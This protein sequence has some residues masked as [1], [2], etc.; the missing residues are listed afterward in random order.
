[1]H[2]MLLAL[3]LLALIALNALYVAAEFAVLGATRP[4]VESR[5]RAGEEWAR[6]LLPVL[7]DA[8]KQDRYIAVAQIG[9]TLASLG[10]GMYGEHEIARVLIPL[11]EV[12]GDGSAVAAH[13]AATA[14]ALVFLTFWHIVL[15][16]MIP[17][18]VAL[19]APLTVARV[20]SLPMAISDFVLRPLVWVLN[21]IGRAVLGLL[22]MPVSS[23]LALVYSPQE[24]GL[25]LRET[26]DVG[27]LEAEPHTRVQNIITFPRQKLRRV[28]VPR[29]HVEALPE[30]TPA[31]TAVEAVREHKFS[32]FPVYRRNIDDIVG[33][34][35]VK[36]LL[37]AVDA[38]RLDRPLRDI[39]R[40]AVYLPQS[41]DLD[42]ALDAMRELHA[43]MAVVLD[44]HGGTAGIVTLEDFVE[45]IFGTVRDEF[46]VEEGHP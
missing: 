37:A 20:V 10:L 42:D 24:L 31:A 44:E 18:S 40:P 35:H 33:I 8:M 21:R 7:T 46:D 19:L 2:L 41:M 28:L 11:F 17:K 6:R 34:V 12:F 23:D 39:M 15:G 32:R 43:H 14:I 29:V 30:G 36:D 27:L 26:H 4:Q 45:E 9:I 38:H 22:R 5:A 13:S 1:M 3:I 25:M 16:E